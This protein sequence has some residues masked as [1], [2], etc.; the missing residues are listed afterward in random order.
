MWV[1]L[2]LLHVYVHARWLHSSVVVRARCP[3]CRLSAPE[4]LCNDNMSSGPLYLIQKRIAEVL[5]RTRVVVH[6]FAR[7]LI[8]WICCHCCCCFGAK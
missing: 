7:V 4:K 2:F 1:F 6:P 3:R 5:L 8:I